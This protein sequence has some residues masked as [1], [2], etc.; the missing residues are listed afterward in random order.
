MQATFDALENPETTVHQGAISLAG[1]DDRLLDVVVRYTGKGEWGS[2]AITAIG[3]YLSYD[4]G[5]ADG[6]KDSAFGYGV[7]LSGVIKVGES[8]NLNFTIISSEGIGRYV[9]LNICGDVVAVP[10]RQLVTVGVVA[11]FASDR[12]SGARGSA[13][14]SPAHASRRST[15]HS[16]ACSLR[17]MSSA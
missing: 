15:L 2:A 3:R 16:P 6:V 4:A 5:V 17:T 14:C 11:G 10:D 1:G 9:G 13:R 7:S 12:H 8:E